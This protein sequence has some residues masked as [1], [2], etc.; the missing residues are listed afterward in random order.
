MNY[1]SALLHPLSSSF[2]VMIYIMSSNEIVI[3]IELKFS[4]LDRAR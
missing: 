1:P 4:V 3:L 2:P